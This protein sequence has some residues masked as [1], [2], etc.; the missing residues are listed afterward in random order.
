MS[1][2]SKIGGNPGELQARMDTQERT[3][4][5]LEREQQARAA[6]T[7]AREATEARDKSVLEIAKR[8]PLSE[9]FFQSPRLGQRP[10]LFNI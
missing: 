9:A 8:R 5:K 7:A 6:K 4:L 2:G 1:S 10:S 3:R